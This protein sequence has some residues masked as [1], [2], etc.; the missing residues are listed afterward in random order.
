VISSP[1]LLDEQ[2]FQPGI[3]ATTKGTKRHEK[4]L[5]CGAGSGKL[6][7]LGMA[8]ALL[9]AEVPFGGVD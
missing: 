5:I 9:L 7:S 1:L 2:Q 8:V 3:S 4:D 6:V